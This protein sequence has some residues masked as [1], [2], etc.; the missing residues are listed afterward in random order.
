MLKLVAV[1]FNGRIFVKANIHIVLF[2]VH[3]CVDLRQFDSIYSIHP[4]VIA[5]KGESNRE[6]NNDEKKKMPK[7]EKTRNRERI[8]HKDR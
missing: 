6:A 7:K 3:V 4:I 5:V 2:H 8:S 1:S